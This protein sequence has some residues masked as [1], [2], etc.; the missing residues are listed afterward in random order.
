MAMEE[1]LPILTVQGRDPRKVTV[2]SLMV[3]VMWAF[4]VIRWDTPRPRSLKLPFIGQSRWVR[5]VFCSLSAICNLVLTITHV[6]AAVLHLVCN[7]KY[8]HHSLRFVAIVLCYWPCLIAPRIVG[9]IAS[10]SKLTNL[11]KD[12]RN[13]TWLHVFDEIQFTRK[14]ELLST[15]RGAIPKFKVL[16]LF[17]SMSLIHTVVRILYFDSFQKLCNSWLSIGWLFLDALGMNYALLMGY[18]IYLQTVALHELR[19]ITISFIKENI[20]KVDPCLEVVKNFFQDYLE[21]RRLLLPMCSFIMFGTTFGTTVLITLNFATTENQS[22]SDFNNTM[23]NE[24]ITPCNVVGVC[25]RYC[26]EVGCIN[27]KITLYFTDAISFYRVL[28]GVVVV[29]A[30]TSFRDIRS[31]WNH[32]RLDLNLMHTHERKEFWIQLETYVDRLIPSHGSDMMT[33][34][35]FPLIGLASALLGGQHFNV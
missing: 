19:K 23:S 4:G 27:D 7:T 9:T 31:V 20:G 34:M 12:G 11:P 6:L 5:K 29:F 18:Y 33:T 15:R 3:L 30:V 22:S 25:S 13:V 32:F 10:L 21:L 1:A 28:I 16:F 35:I 8:I 24:S 26:T 14:L 2:T 17:Q